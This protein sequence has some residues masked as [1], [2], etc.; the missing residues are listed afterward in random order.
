[1][2]NVTN[3]VITPQ[4]KEDQAIKEA[5]ALGHQNPRGCGKHIECLYANGADRKIEDFLHVEVSDIIRDNVRYTDVD[6][7][8]CNDTLHP[9]I[10]EELNRNPQGL[11]LRYPLL[12]EKRGSKYSL[13]SG[14][15]RLWVYIN[16]L[17]A[18]TVPVFV[19]EDKGS[20]LD[21]TIGAILANNNGPDVSREYQWTDVVSQLQKISSLGGFTKLSDEEVTKKEFEIWMDK[22]SPHK[23]KS[24]KW[25]GRIFKS[26]F[27][28]NSNAP[29]VEI[30]TDENFW[31]LAISRNGY[32]TRY[33][34]QNGKKKKYSSIHHTCPKNK[35]IIL[36]GKADGTSN[37]REIFMILNEFINNQNYSKTYKGYNI[38]MIRAIKKTKPT[39]TEMMDLRKKDRDLIDNW[40]KMLSNFKGSLR[41][42]KLIYPAQ[43]TAETADTIY[44]INKNN[45]LV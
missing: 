23:F 33:Y 7:K 4:Q 39:P 38:H 2:N 13:I 20:Q 3:L 9:N 21:K 5:M 12:A 11:G 29:A 6:I 25:R 32:P 14:H 18:T 42:T 28:N 16:L 22:I 34:Y 1:M 27:S 30:T 40:N 8:V 41:I 15:N 37:E 26:F 24:K 19:V 43:L 45:K 36:T 35:A 31:D 44:R 10:E 17:N